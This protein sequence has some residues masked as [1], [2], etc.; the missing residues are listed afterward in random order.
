MCFYDISLWTLYRAGTMS[1]LA[2]AYTKCIKIFF[3]HHKFY[4]ATSMLMEL[5]LL[6]FNTVLFNAVVTF[7]NRVSMSVNSLVKIAACV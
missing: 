2:A 5:R 3:G 1:K 6:S 4:S 7:N